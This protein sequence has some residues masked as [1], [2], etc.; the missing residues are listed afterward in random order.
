MKIS[1][2][3]PMY[4]EEKVVA[5]L[6]ETLFS[7]MEEHFFGEYEVVLINDG[8]TD[9]TEKE[10][11]ERLPETFC[12]ISYPK[13]RGKGYAL[14]RGMEEAQGDI[15]F[16]TD[17]DL[18]YGTEVI[19]QFY[20]VLSENQKDAAVGSRS[21]HPDGYRGYGFLRRVASRAYLW[22]LHTYGG[23]SL[24]DSQCGCKAYRK[25]AGKEIFAL[26]ET[27]GFAF[28]MEAILIGQKMGIS[29]CEVPV[30]IKNHGKS[31]V[32]V[33]RDTKRM[34]HDLSVIKKRVKKMTLSPKKEKR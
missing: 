26:V 18:A 10:A 27:D 16:F 11:K 13:N 22:L 28:D 19:E 6:I 15:L 5:S 8:S 7:Y 34:L 21:L 24:S 29:F 31:S 14:R 12:L 33:F 32:H 4:N 9:Q 23:L 1:V 30:L 25:Q 17:C 3:I 20:R 2:L